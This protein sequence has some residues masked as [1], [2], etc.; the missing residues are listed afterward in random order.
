MTVRRGRVRRKKVCKV[1]ILFSE[2]MSWCGHDNFLISM[3]RYYAAL[4]GHVEILKL[5]RK[6][7][8]L[9]QRQMKKLM[10]C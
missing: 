9:F 7:L 5:L 4:E 8:S 10:M 3:N 2:M 6:V 1:L